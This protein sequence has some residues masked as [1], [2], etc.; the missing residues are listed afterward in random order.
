VFIIGV[1][2]L[3]EI[4]FAKP[5]L[6]A[7]AGGFIPTALNH[8]ALLIAI[9]IIGATVMPHNLYLH[10]S[11]VQTRKI[12]TDRI[13]VKRAIRLNIFDSTIALNMAFFVN[14]AIL[15]LAASVFYKNGMYEVAEIQDAH[16]L[17]APMLG[18]NL[19]PIL[20][21]VALIAAGQSSTITG[22]L[23][24]QIVME[25]YINLRIHPWVRRLLTRCIA[26]APALIVIHIWGESSTGRMLILSQVV[27]SL[28]LGFAIIP[29]IHF[30]SDKK[31]M[32]EFAIKPLVKM[33]AW[34][35]AI[36]IVALNIKLVADEMI[37]VF[38]SD[39][40]VW[41]KTGLFVICIGVG[42]LLLITTLLPIM[43]KR[44][45]TQIPLHNVDGNIHLRHQKFTRIAVAV[46]FTES[47]NKSIQHAIAMGGKD[48]QY[49]FIHIVESAGAWVAGK[50]IDDYETEQDEKNLSIYARKI[51]DEGFHV[52]TKIGF[53]SPKKNIPE[54]VKTFHA[55]LLVMGSHGHGGL[56]DFLLGTTVESVRHEVNIPVLV[57]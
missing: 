34:L 22:T 10:S 19:A 24:G 28:Q 27:L 30:V 46:D 39:S 21:A 11:L 14:A 33:L 15:I 17:L 41:L 23:A 51:T 18:T 42:L 37:D 35:S 26:I 6:A 49:L 40:S 47:D 31:K 52:E 4:F 48:A 53:G 54:F 50:E 3:T 2:F 9:G 25:G 13:S 7:I 32:G 20:F 38:N 12:D 44:N 29:L 8:E 5:D 55:D 56:K 36:V 16:K 57:V 1:A 43:L 45:I